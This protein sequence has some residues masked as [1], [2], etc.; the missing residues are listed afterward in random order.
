MRWS[1]RVLL[2][3][4]VSLLPSVKVAAQDLPGFIRGDI[5]GDLSIDLSDPILLLEE[6]FGAS[7]GLDCQAAADLDADGQLQLD[8]VIVSLGHIFLAN[9]AQLPAP[10]PNCGTD[11]YSGALHATSPPASSDRSSQNGSSPS[12]VS[13]KLS[14]TSINCRQCS[15]RRSRGKP[16][17]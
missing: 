1:V 6:L 3:V 9:P 7:Q 14:P 13:A 5:N 15:S 4:T 16:A 11:E 2:I 17:I 10:F 8:D 12:P